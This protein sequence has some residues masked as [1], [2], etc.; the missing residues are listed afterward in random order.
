MHHAPIIRLIMR[1]TD[2]MLIIAF[3]VIWVIGM[4]LF[5]NSARAAQQRRPIPAEQFDNRTHIWL[6]RAMVA[7]GGWLSANDHVATA[8]VYSRRWR[9]MNARWPDLRF[10]DV[11]FRYSKG[12]GAGR[13]QY[14]MRQVWIRS[15]SPS[16][17]EPVGWPSNVSWRRHKSFWARALRRAAFW[18]EG[19]LR[20][21]CR[22]K[23]QYFGGEMDLPTKR[24]IAVKCKGVRNI[25]YRIGA[26]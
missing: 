6:A 26:K 11:L 25:F 20:D 19:K 18:S 2:W 12:L 17:A 3:T 7:E 14:S 22:G 8:F 15:L 16:M 4:A 9:A 21:P 23:A 5:I 10:L 24:L 1:K 13:R